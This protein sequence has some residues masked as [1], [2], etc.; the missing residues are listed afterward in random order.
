MNFYN[1]HQNILMLKN[2]KMFLK[3]ELPEALLIY[4]EGKIIFSNDEARKIFPQINLNVKQSDLFRALE[5]EETKAT[6]FCESSKKDKF[7]TVQNI[8]NEI[9]R[10]RIEEPRKF[11]LRLKSIEDKDQYRFLEMRIGSKY[12]II[13]NIINVGWEI[14]PSNYYN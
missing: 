9:E 11:N 5:L 4:Q 8:M 12:L 7:G 1:N 3:R 2:F 14:E 10:S 6:S 13:L